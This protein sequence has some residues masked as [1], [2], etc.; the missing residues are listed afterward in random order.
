MRPARPVQL[1]PN[2]E[3]AEKIYYGV[4]DYLNQNWQERPQ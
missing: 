3:S 1:F 2:L 4:T